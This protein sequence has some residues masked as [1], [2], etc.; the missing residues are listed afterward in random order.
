[1]S[2]FPNPSLDIQKRKPQNFILWEPEMVTD[3]ALNTLS[4][5]PQYAQLFSEQWINGEIL[6]GLDHQALLQIGFPLGTFL[7]L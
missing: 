6:A 7:K 2:L 1:M 5:T 4:L 3:W